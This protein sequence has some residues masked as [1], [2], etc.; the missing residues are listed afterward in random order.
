MEFKYTVKDS[1]KSIKQILKNE[2]NMS[3]RYILKLKKNKCIQINGQSVHINYPIFDGD[4]LYIFENFAEDS[5]NIVPNQDI[6]LKILFEDE[7][8]LI[9][10]KQPG[11][12]VH[13]SILHYENSLSNCV[14]YYFNQIGLNKKIRPVNRLDKDTSGIVLFAKND[15]IQECLVKQMKS[16]TFK[17]YYIAILEGIVENESGTI[18][19]PIARKDGSIIAREI[20]LGGETAISHYKVIKKFSYKNGNT[21]FSL[22]KV[23][24]SL[25]TGRTHQIRLHSKHIGHPIV[26]DTLYGNPSELISRQAL[27]A[28]KVEF[29]HPV[30]K[31]MI[32]IEA[33]IPNDMSQILL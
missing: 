22:T 1:D 27:H 7:Y 26:G 10:D 33:E 32:S 6:P 29:I 5:S 17:K 15:Y 25:E 21:L 4:I 9:V 12:P 3:E 13:P 30:T 23:E 19:A 14:K 28:Y 31:K 18:S 24:F 2:L 11:I 16:N 20:S 8:L